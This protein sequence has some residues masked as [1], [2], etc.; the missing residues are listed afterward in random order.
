[1]LKTCADALDLP[2]ALLARSILKAGTWPRSWKIHWVFPLHRRKSK[3][4]PGNYRGIHLTP[5]LSKVIERLIGLHIQPYLESSFAY[6]PNQFA[7]S[8]ERGAKDILALNILEWISAINR[9]YRVALYC[10]DVSGA[11]DCV[12][13]DRLGEKLKSKGIHEQLLPLLKSW[14]AERTAFVIVDGSQSQ[15]QPLSNSVYQG[16]VLGPPLWNCFFAD[17]REAVTKHGYKDHTFADD[18]NCFKAFDAAV[19]DAAVLSDAN[20]CR[21]SLHRWG[22]ANRV[23]FDAS[24][25]SFHIIHNRRLF[26]EHFKIL[27]VTFDAKLTMQTAALEISSR[28]SW[29]LRSLI[30]TQRYF[31]M[32]SLITLYK[33]NI[34]SV[35]E[36]ATPAL[37]HAP[38][39]MLWPIDRAQDTLLTELGLPPEEALAR[40][41]LAPLT[42]RRDISMLGLLHRIVLGKAP[43]QFSKH[44][45]KATRPNFPRDLR[46]PDKRH[47]KQLHDPIDGTNLPIVQRSVLGLVYTYNALPQHVVDAKTVCCFQRRLQWCLL[48]LTTAGASDWQTFLRNGVRSMPIERF[49]SQFPTSRPHQPH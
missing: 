37:Y 39:F 30:R 32:E 34:L 47:S 21:T 23:R 12:S 45:C 22:A 4:E 46:A 2:V 15:P 10:S 5:Q 19:P 42:A 7:Y 1:M 33:T 9:G 38:P 44:V 24:K 6:G 13:A 36:Y 40:F 18:L 31:S 26:G 16:T 14:L 43:L 27:G 25:E 48:R 35:L 29:M 41:N 8:R 20:A 28:A 49:Q 11:F 3:A 17:A